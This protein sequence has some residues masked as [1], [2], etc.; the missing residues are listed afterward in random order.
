MRDIL[1]KLSEMGVEEKAAQIYVF[2]L[3]N[4]D[5]PVYKVATGTKIPRTTVYNLLLELE[6]QGL[7]SSWKKNNVMHYS[8]EHPDRLKQILQHKQTILNDIYGELHDL[9]TV[10]KDHPRT[11]V[12]VGTEGLKQTFAHILDI[13]IRDKV[14]ISYSVTELALMEAL[15]RF[16]LE[17]RKVKNKKTSC[18]S[19]LIVPKGTAQQ[20]NYRSDDFRET[21]EIPDEN[22]FGSTMILIG[23]CTYFFS[24]KGNEPY[25]IIIE[26]KIVADML[27]KLFLYIWK[28]L[29]PVSAP[30]KTK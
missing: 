19:Y 16:F 17:W 3:R 8:A 27:T 30:V 7:V 14:K 29:E 11:K 18:F 1:K 9:Y 28:S 24:F 15:P 21:R 13:M 23:S 4:R 25:S 26:S 10:E 6:S 5:I 2:L 20:E 22:P 12:F